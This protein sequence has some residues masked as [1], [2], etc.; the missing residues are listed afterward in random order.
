MLLQTLHDEEKKLTYEK[1]K[2]M[3]LYLDDKLTGEAVGQQYKPLDERHAQIKTMIPDLQGEIDFL[4]IQFLASDQVLHDAK[5]LYGR[6][7]LLSA[8]E[9]RSI[10]ETITEVIKVG[11]DDIFI[12][13]AYIPSS[14]K[15]ASGR[16]R[17]VR[18]S[19]PRQA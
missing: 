8:E 17:N 11:K 16:S 19:L 2:I 12:K 18:G 7:N 1:N 5:D 3:R 4:K 15:M 10:I 6:W 9:K 14:S 13:L